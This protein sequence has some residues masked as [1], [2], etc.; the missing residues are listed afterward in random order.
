MC[1]KCGCIYCLYLL[2]SL[3]K[4]FGGEVF[5]CLLCPVISRNKDVI[6]SLQLE[7]LVSKMEEREAQLPTS[8]SCSTREPNNA[9]FPR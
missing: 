4:D 9:E 2:D 6:A 7:K 1:L 5:W 8:A 3:Q